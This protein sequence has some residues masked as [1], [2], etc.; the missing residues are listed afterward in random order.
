MDGPRLPTKDRKGK[1]KCELAKAIC[2][3][4]RYCWHAEILLC[5][6]QRYCSMHAQ[7]RNCRHKWTLWRRPSRWR[8]CQRFNPWSSDIGMRSPRYTIQYPMTQAVS[9][10]TESIYICILMHELIREKPRKSCSWCK[11]MKSKSNC[12]W[13]QCSG[14]RVG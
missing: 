6:T 7:T 8:M 5:L 3:T 9:S 10:V 4:Q 14:P 2:L 13:L 12:P 1:Q 11:R